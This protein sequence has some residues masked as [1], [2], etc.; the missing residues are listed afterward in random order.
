MLL[1]ESASG[2][3]S[4]AMPV[5]HEGQKKVLNLPARYR[6][7]VCGRRFGKTVAAAI[8]AVTH[9]EEARTR[10]RVW[11]IAP[12][13]AQADLV[14]R[15]IAYWLDLRA[16]EEEEKEKQEKKD[17]IAG[18]AKEKKTKKVSEMTEEERKEVKHWRWVYRK[19]EHTLE[20]VRSGSRIEFHSAHVPDRLRG[21][22]LELV[23]IDE[24]A[25]IT[26]DTWKMVVKPMLLEGRG[27]AF[28]IGTPR[29][30]RHWLH[31]VFM[32]GQRGES[33]YASIRLPTSQNPRI[34]A[35]ELEEYKAD[36]TE[37]EFRQEFEAEFI[38]GVNAAFTKIDE[39][40]SGEVRA[41][42]ERGEF[43][44]TGIDLGQRK[45]FTVLCSL[46]CQRERVEGFDRFNKLDW[47]VQ[48]RRI[49][50]HLDAFPGACMVDATGVGGSV[51]EQLEKTL[52][53]T[54][55]RFTFTQPSRQEM[56]G[57]LQVAFAHEQ[58]KL[59]KVPMLLEEL[60][61][62]TLLEKTDPNGT[63]RARYGAPEG[64]HD[65]CVMAL[66]LAWWGLRKKGLWGGVRGNPLRDGMFA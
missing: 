65:D 33:N 25:D 20:H 62:F 17:S 31:R 5:P 54:L 34:D 7:A 64:E 10:Q 24:A 56:L 18:D 6:V 57:A 14:E 53:L 29:G 22:G 21:A 3:A 49:K 40:V 47:D 36:M 39:A 45:N 37:E 52:G 32:T 42:G 28:I 15:E 26:E 41:K 63:T 59:A 9:C 13:Q 19:S 11:W 12:V 60:R 38:D 8:A 27:K 48:C 23:V 58:I 1:D 51:C 16:K 46:N 61:G 66:G 50:A 4:L 2:E 55:H 44:I 30:T 35:K 43:Y